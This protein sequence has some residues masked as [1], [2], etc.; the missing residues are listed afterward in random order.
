MKKVIFILS[1]LLLVCGCEKK[2]NDVPNDEQVSPP[3]LQVKIVDVNSKTRPIAVMINNLAA[4]RPYQSGLQDAY[5]VYE[6]IV[7]G[8]ITRYMA[9][10]KDASTER[11]GSVRSSRHYY[12]DYVLENDAIYAHWGYSTQA[13]SDIKKLGIN[14]INGLVYEGKYFYRDRKLNV[15]TEHTGFTSMAL[16][17]EGIEKLKY[18]KTTEKGLLLEYSPTSIDLN[19][20]GATSD[21]NDITLK[22][23]NTIINNYKY[24]PENKNY[25]RFVNQKEQ[26]DYVTKEQLTVKNII[27]YKVKNDKI[28][29][30]SKGRQELY[31]IGN[32]E[33]YYIT[34]GKAIKIKWQK[35]SRES[36]TIYT[37]ENGTPLIV[38][39]GNTFMQIVPEIGDIVIK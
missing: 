15:S 19:E 29:N 1:I 6:L 33:G 39:D 23:S 26:I 22:Y 17:N 14:N 12:L 3:A 16:L 36:K 20:Y 28:T 7:E 9:L 11:I 4:A 35:T 5:M 34:E 2:Q 25:K 21:A 30:D 13:K 37:Y 32:G 38:N 8:G 27:V 31:N 18:R 10:F 24:D